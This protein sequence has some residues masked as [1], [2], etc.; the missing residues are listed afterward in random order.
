MPLCHKSPGSYL[1]VDPDPKF[2]KNYDGLEKTDFHT[3][4]W[5]QL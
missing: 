2:A 4:L 3:D 1:N 5:T